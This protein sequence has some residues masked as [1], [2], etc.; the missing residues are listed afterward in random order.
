MVR[1]EKSSSYSV[2]ARA[3]KRSGQLSGLRPGNRSRKRNKAAQWP[4][5]RYVSCRS[6]SGSAP[7]PWPGKPEEPPRPDSAHSAWPR[8]VAG[9]RLQP[10]RP[11]E[12]A[13]LFRADAP[14]E[15]NRPGGAQGMGDAQIT[16]PGRDP[17]HRESYRPPSHWARF[18][19]RREFASSR[20]RF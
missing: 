17:P 1:P 2:G 7:R 9:P 15:G 11:T 13:V 5:C 20:Y 19:A 8:K 16:Y 4:P 3:A 10:C 12:D 18:L 14:D 6:A